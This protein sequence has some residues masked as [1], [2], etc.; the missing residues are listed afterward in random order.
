MQCAIGNS[1]RLPKATANVMQTP[2]P[3]ILQKL[4]VFCHGIGGG[5]TEYYNFVH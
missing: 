4:R 2:C 3:K 5:L 1:S